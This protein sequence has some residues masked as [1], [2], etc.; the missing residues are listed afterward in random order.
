MKKILWIGT[1]LSAVITFLC[2]WLL[3]LRV[4]QA[5]AFFTLSIW[6]YITAYRLKDEC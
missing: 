3:E 2:G 1:L 5:G 6:L 4:N